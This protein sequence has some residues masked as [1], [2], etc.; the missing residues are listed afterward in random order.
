LIDWLPQSDCDIEAL[1]DSLKSLSGQDCV[2][3]KEGLHGTSWQGVHQ[4]SVWK[5]S[6]NNHNCLCGELNFAIVLQGDTIRAC[7]SRPHRAKWS[8]KPLAMRTGA[9]N[10]PN[11]PAPR[12]YRIHIRSDHPILTQTSRSP[13]SSQIEEI[14]E[15][16]SI[17]AY[18]GISG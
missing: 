18:A 3:D 7:P 1:P 13:F 11:I 10:V 2:A 5:D 15:F 4:F 16:V 9:L 8:I 12:S 6:D 14:P 17:S